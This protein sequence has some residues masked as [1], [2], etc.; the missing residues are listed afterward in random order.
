MADV[1]VVES[2]SPHVTV[3]ITKSKTDTRQ[4]GRMVVIAAQ[5]RDGINILD[6]VRAYVSAAAPV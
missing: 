2:P 6:R 4:A 3:H 5:S 1:Q